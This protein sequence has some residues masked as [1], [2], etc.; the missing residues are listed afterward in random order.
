M[1]CCVVCFSGRISL[2]NL[3]RVARELEENMSEEELRAMIEEFDV[4]SD[5]ESECSRGL[6]SIAIKG[7]PFP[8]F[9]G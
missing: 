1:L 9:W 3:R 4:D 8:Y 5:G 2:R 7:I 6:S